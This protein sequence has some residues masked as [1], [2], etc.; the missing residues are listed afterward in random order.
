MIRF[1]LPVALLF[2]S[3]AASALA[4]TPATFRLD[5]FH[6]GNAEEERF[7]LDGVVVEGDWAGH[8]GRRLDNTNLGRYRFSVIDPLTQGT[9]YSR[10]FASIYG[11]WETTGEAISGT[12]RTLPEALRLPAPRKPFQ[13]RLRKRQSDQS[14]GEIWNT[15][16]DPKSRFVDRSTVP[17]DSAW[18]VFMTPTVRWGSHSPTRSLRRFS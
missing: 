1:A 3:A 15:T 13:I 12:M 14:F 9:L 4:A 5:Y 11:E 18:A 8:P 6:T 10:G 7:A 2:A 16:V 17:T